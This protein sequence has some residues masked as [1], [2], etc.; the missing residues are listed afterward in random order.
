MILKIKKLDLVYR[1][2]KISDY[3]QFRKL[4]FLCFKKKISYDFFK[5][6]YFSNKFSFCYGAFEASKL[7]A[8]VGMISMKLNNNTNERIFSR[9]SSMVLKKYRGCGIYSELLNIVKNKISKRV[10]F[11]AMWPNKNNH[12]NFG[13]SNKNIIKR[14]YFLYETNLK[15]KSKISKITESNNI[16][17]LIKYKNSIKNKNN[18]FY[19]NFIYLNNRYLS[20]RKND[21]L[22]NK[23]K[24]KNLTSFF[25]LKRN[26][27]KLGLKHVILDHFGSKRIKSR[28]LTYLINE[29]NKLIFLS[30][31]KI[32][33]N[34][35]RLLNYLT[36]K[37]GFIKKYNLKYKNRIL[38]N[39]EIF[40]GDTDIFMTIGDN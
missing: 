22:I 11:V 23:F 3:D 17:Q 14:K 39:K 7:I 31:K 25:I 9:H 4:F 32:Y 15:T 19:K 36:L 8:N 40:L 34:N 33:K 37:I 2:L 30:N 12:A 28:H 26:N 10:R 29:Q 6:R 18:F 20:Y 27:D 38:S 16:E 21:Y 13:I 35:F 5:W 24:F 1:K